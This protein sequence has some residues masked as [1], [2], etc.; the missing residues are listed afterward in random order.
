MGADSAKFERN[1]KEVQSIVFYDFPL[2]W[3][4][5]LGHSYEHVRLAT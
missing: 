2:L 4:R 3:N 5:K 1:E